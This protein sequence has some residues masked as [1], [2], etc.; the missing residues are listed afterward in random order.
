MLNPLKALRGFLAR[1]EHGSQALRPSR[2]T[3]LVVETLEDRRVLSVSAGALPSIAGTVFTDDNSNGMMDTGEGVEGAIVRLFLDDGDGIFEPGTDDVQV[4]ADLLTDANGEYCFDNLDQ[5][6]NYFVQQPAQQVNGVTLAEMASALI[7]CEPQLIIDSFETTQSTS[8][9]PPPVS[10]DQSSLSLGGT[11]V[12][13]GERDLAVELQ[14][15]TSEVQLRVNP[16]GLSDVLIFDS[17]AGTTGLREVTWDGVDN[18]GDTLA[19]G[20]GGIDLTQGGTLQG[21]T[22]LMGVDANGANAR[23]RIYQ[24]NSGNFSEVTRAIPVTGGA[25]TSW[26]FIPFTDFVGTV[27]ASNV[28]AIQLFIDTGNDSVDGQIDSIGVLGPKIN[29]FQNDVQIDLELTKTTTSTTVN[30]GDQVTWTLSLSNNAA[31][32]NVP[33]TG[34]VVDDVIPAGV[35]FVSATPSVGTY[36][37]GTWTLTGVS[38]APGATETLTLVTSVDGAIAGGTVLENVAEVTAHD[39]ADFDSTPGND[40]GDQSE[41]DEANAS[42]TVGE[43]IDLEVTKVASSAIVS[44][45]DQVTFTVT[46]TNDANTANTAATNVQVTDTLPAG[47]TLVSATPSGNGVFSNGIWSLIDPLAIGGSQ[48]LSVV[49]SVD[50]DVMGDASLMNVAEVTSA[51]EDDADSTPDNDDGDQSEDDE[52]NATV[53]VGAVIDLELEKSVNVA[54]VDAG[55]NVV[56][57]VSVTNDPT[58]ANTA[59]T[60]VQV[61][62]VLPTGVTLVSATPSGNGTFANGV[63]S[64]VDPLQPGS[65]ATLTMMT[66]V[67]VGTAGGSALINSA[68]V[69]AADQQDIDSTPANDNGDRSEDDEDEAQITVNSVIDLELTKTT[70]SSTVLVGDQVTWTVSLTNNAANANADATGVTVGDI[71]PTGL[72]FVSATPSSGTF[73]T[74]TWTLG[75]ALAPGATETLTLVTTVNSSAPTTITNEAEV[76]AATET[77]IDSTPGNDDGDQSEDDEDNASISVT[78]SMIDLELQK[79]VSATTV[80]TGDQVTWMITLTNNAANANA[81]ATGVQ[82]TDILPTGVTLQSSSPSSGT[83][84]GG[85]W[86][87]GGPIEPGESETLNIVTSIDS[88]ASGGDVLTNTV[89]VTAATEPD[90]DSMPGNDDGDQSEDEEASAQVTLNNIVDLEV[91]KQVDQANVEVG[92]QVTWTITVSNNAANANTSATGVTIADVLPAGV[93]FVSAMAT[94]GSYNSTSG[95][96]TLAAAL[97]PGES[98]TLTI[99]TIVE[100][101]AAGSSLL[102]VAEVASQDQDDID[103]Q[104]ANDNGDQSQDDEDPA[105]ID[106]GLVRPISKRDLLAF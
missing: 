61:T 86:T 75:G 68:Q 92:D 17:S 23:F 34:I 3:R 83:Y 1:R 65:V 44:A 47:L 10:S 80:N 89:Q 94:N 5:E 14:A 29:D 106:I 32:A 48:T 57:T 55:D 84:A 50:N 62:D 103:S 54:T 79:T 52:A 30:N 12:I 67:D 24:G 4:G 73:I 21:I 90:F 35:S 8:A 91:D 11:E 78:P 42:V 59:A 77:D 101:T 85:V 63:W 39:Q 98:S 60:N 16:F 46:I 25:A 69:S 76:T 102:N 105:T 27:D 104:P 2:K 81:A 96:W 28:D 9:L 53:M 95:I 37:N 82:V 87:L 31:N 13:G 56:W 100:S 22:S 45:G 7:E 18:D 51:N 49:A 41:D 20:L 26:V 36:T 64:L 99:V 74:N 88:S 40:D 58:N 15:G 38:L 97:A 71:L 66:S 6:S 93:S 19:M 43:F 70:T 33:A 72:D